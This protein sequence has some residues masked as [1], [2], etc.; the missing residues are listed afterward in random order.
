MVQPLSFEGNVRGCAFEMELAT[1]TAPGHQAPAAG[2]CCHAQ[3][4]V[5]HF[6]QASQ[7]TAE[8]MAIIMPHEVEKNKHSSSTT[9]IFF[10][11]FFSTFSDS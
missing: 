7:Q 10:E 11:V 6:L 2:A 4:D 8:S 5:W 1:H 3:T 9:P